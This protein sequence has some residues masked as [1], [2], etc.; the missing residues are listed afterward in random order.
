MTK[1]PNRAYL[2]EYIKNQIRTGTGSESAILYFDIDDFNAINDIFGHKEGDE[3]LIKIGN[4][5]REITGVNEK[6]FRQGGDEF[7]VVFLQY[8]SRDDIT[9]FVK[10]LNEKLAEPIKLSQS[11]FHVTLSGGIVVFPGD[12]EDYDTL[13]KNADIAMYFV[14]NNGKN[15]L[16]YFNADMLEGAKEKLL[17]DHHLRSAVKEMDFSIQYQP[18]VDMKTGRIC[19]FEALIR[20]KDDELGQVPPS[21][22]IKRAEENGLIVPIGTWILRESCSFAAELALKG[23]RDV[24]VSINLSPIQLRQKEFVPL[25]EEIL[26]QTGVK[27]DR[28]EFEITETIL[29]DS[30]ESSLKKLHEIKALGISISLDDFGQGY[31]SLTYLRMLPI[32]T[33]KIDKSFLDDYCDE[34]RNSQII[35]AIIGL[36]HGMRLKVVAEGVETEEQYQFLKDNGCDMIQGFLI[37]KPVSIQETE[38]L[39]CSHEL[40]HKAAENI[41]YNI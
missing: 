36:A 28:I 32:T 23:Y 22:F 2:K 15:G 20:W 27:S 12:G 17:L 13:M 24:S 18:I 11:A 25:V 35:P 1:L 9:E 29:I 10:K 6:V 34:E 21:V 4:I 5:L 26:K 40:F 39:L 14:K 16:M 33:L 38:Q 41:I 8:H 19:K 31:S 30:L 37:S 3:L 7:A